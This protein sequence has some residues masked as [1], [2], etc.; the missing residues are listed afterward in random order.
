[1][2]WR[3]IASAGD[4]QPGTRVIRLQKQ[5]LDTGVPPLTPE[6]STK[7]TPKCSLLCIVQWLSM[8]GCAPKL[9]EAIRHWLACLFRSC[10]GVLHHVR[11]ELESEETRIPSRVPGR[12][13]ACRPAATIST[14]A[15]LTLAHNTSLGSNK[16][17]AIDQCCNDGPI[18]LGKVPRGSPRAKEFRYDI[19]PL[20]RCRWTWQRDLYN[21]VA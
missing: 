21:H 17:F 6:F 19:H 11:P 20:G 18:V 12:V 10:V 3:C 14:P 15:L 13:L 7:F 1:M 4:L 2:S 5:A 8:A 16:R 9:C